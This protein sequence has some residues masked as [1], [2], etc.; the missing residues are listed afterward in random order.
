MQRLELTH[1]LATSAHSLSMGCNAGLALSR[2]HAGRRNRLVPA[3]VARGAQESEVD[4][5]IIN[6]SN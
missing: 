1:Q 5:A 4:L 3:T 2:G 6:A